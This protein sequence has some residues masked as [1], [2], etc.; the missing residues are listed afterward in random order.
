MTA[1]PLTCDHCRLPL[2]PTALACPRC[3]TLV[4]REH[5]R[6]LSSR[7]TALEVSDPA[8]AAALWQQ[9]LSLLPNNSGQYQTIVARI[10]RLNPPR[11]QP[12]APSQPESTTGAH[13]KQQQQQQQTQTLARAVS[14]TF[15]S[16]FVSAL[17]YAQIADWWFAVGLVLSILVHELGHS[18][19][20][21]RWRIRATPPIFIP[22][23]G[24]FIGL[25]DR[26]RNVA[27]EAYI[28]IAGPIFGTLAGLACWFWFTSTGSALAWRLAEFSFFINLANLL[29]FRPLDGGRVIVAAVPLFAR[30]PYWRQPYYLIPKRTSVFIG[31]AYLLVAGVLVA[32]FAMAR[33]AGKSLA[34]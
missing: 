18:L 31:I 11:P 23:L 2:A 32:L 8:G 9:C 14:I 22:L 17:V 27:I 34:V 10:A 33:Q 29:P 19:A 30:G 25:K 24:A 5:L 15:V 12:H 1:A 3:G 13:P 6:E 7:A 20:C 26:P 4:Y 28:G 16:M 21:L